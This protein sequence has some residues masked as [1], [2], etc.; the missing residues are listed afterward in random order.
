VL[1]RSMCMLASDILMPNSQT[2]SINLSV[3]PKTS[4]LS[5]SSKQQP[6][7]FVSQYL[8]SYRFH[9]QA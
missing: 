4:S 1:M 7:H 2:P 5:D 8:Y 3:P 6:P 9:Y